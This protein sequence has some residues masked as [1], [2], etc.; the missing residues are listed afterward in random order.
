MVKWASVEQ[1]V[2]ESKPKKPTRSWRVSVVEGEPDL[3]PAK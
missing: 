2:V 1:V 3:I